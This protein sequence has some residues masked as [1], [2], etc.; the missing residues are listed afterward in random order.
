MLLI[1]GLAGLLLMAVGCSDDD[2][3]STT[4]P[5]THDST[6]TTSWDEA[7]GHWVSEVDGSDYD[8][9]AYF[10]FA[11]KDTVTIGT[12]KP[13]ASVWDI[14]FRRDAVK[15]NGGSS[16]TNGG[17]VQG[18]DLGFVDFGS[19]TIA[20]TAGVE[21]VDDAIDYFIDQWYTYNPQTH[22]LAANQY[23]Y[24]MVDAGG[25][26]YLKFRV[27]SMPNAGQ[28]PAMGDVYITYYYQDTT[29]VMNLTGATQEG[30]IDV[31]D[32]T[33]YFDFSAGTQ[34]YPADASSSLDWDIGFSV[35]NCFQNSGPFGNGA[36]AAF[37]A[38]GE[39][40]DPTDI[41]GFIA[42]PGGAPL[43]QDVPSSAFSGWYNYN[44]Q[45]H[46]LT[47]K[48][49]VYLIKTGDVVYKVRVESYYKNMSGVPVSGHYSFIW[50]EL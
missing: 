5:I 28:P 27:D 2:D 42:Q 13:L 8:S 40:G 14:A 23:V 25:E 6:A 38:W 37:L 50:L 12:G 17:D 31:G 29:G 48:S 45:T 24:S 47:S 41:D 15:L 11:I 22:S 33:G 30:V 46:T 35:Y 18:A 10:S 3:G 4:G 32:S 49:H 43:F 36:C 26:N 21:W 9:Y 19:V 16:T 44:G 39:L 34:V 1:L 7:G 20:D